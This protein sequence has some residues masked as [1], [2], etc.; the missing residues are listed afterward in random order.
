[1]PNTRRS[2]CPLSCFLDEWGD[3]WT[4]LILRDLLSG[5]RKFSGFLESAEPLP[6]NLLSNRLVKLVEGGYAIKIQYQERPKRFEYEITD[7]GRSLVPIMQAMIGWAETHLDSVAAA[8]AGLTAVEAKPVK[9]KPAS[10]K[11]AAQK[12]PKQ[13][14][15]TPTAPSQGA[16]DF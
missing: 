14:N 9:A 5:P 6:T 7:K 13:T 10:A 3:K 16:F 11:P 12:K 2:D 1:M 8:P 4:F 15:E